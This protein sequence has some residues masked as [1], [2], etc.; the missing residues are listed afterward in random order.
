M[1][2]NN[3]L[4]QMKEPQ[5]GG[6]MSSKGWI[7]ILGTLVVLALI[8]GLISN[9]TEIEVFGIPLRPSYLVLI[10]FFGGFFTGRFPPRQR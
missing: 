10:A 1:A 6:G 3:D 8:V 4:N 7:G 9:E 2:D 5:R